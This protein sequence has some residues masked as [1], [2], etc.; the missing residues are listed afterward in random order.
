MFYCDKC[1]QEKELPIT[2]SK[3]YGRCEICGE[4]A[5]CHNDSD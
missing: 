5:E 2:W 4:T 3:N 1:R